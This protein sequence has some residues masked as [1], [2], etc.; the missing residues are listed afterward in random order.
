MRMI[1]CLILFLFDF[2]VG[3]ND[4]LG[5]HWDI[6]GDIGMPDRDTW[7]SGAKLAY[8]WINDP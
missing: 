1:S 8:L 7:V 2:N 4:D 3:K 6:L 5:V